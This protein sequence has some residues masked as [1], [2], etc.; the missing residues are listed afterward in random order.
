MSGENSV[1]V[2]KIE[3]NNILLSKLSIQNTD[4]VS[5]NSFFG[6]I[7]SEINSLSQNTKTSED[8]LVEIKEQQNNEEKKGW[9]EKL[10]EKALKIFDYTKLSKEDSKYA[11]NGEIDQ[12]FN[13]GQI[14]DCVLLADLYSISSTQ[15]GQD[16][17][18]DAIKIN[19]DKK[20]N[21]ESYNV[22]FKG[23]DKTYNITHEELKEAERLKLQYE[24]GDSEY[25]F[26]YGDD[27]VLLIELAWIKACADIEELQKENIPLEGFDGP[28]ALNGV[29]PYKFIKA[30]T[31]AVHSTYCGKYLN[32]LSDEQIAQQTPV[33]MEVLENQEEFKF[34]D[35]AF[36]NKEEHNFYY[37][38]DSEKKQFK[39]D[40]EHI[41]IVEQKPSESETGEVIIRNKE[42]GEVLTIKA[43][44]LIKC[45]SSSPLNPEND[46]KLFDYEF[47]RIINSDFVFGAV[48]NNPIEITDIEG[49]KIKLPA[50]HAYGIKEVTDDTITFINP[51]NSDKEFTITKDELYSHDPGFGLSG[52]SIED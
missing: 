27:D 45:V 49:N 6:S 41:Y 43:E 25:H 42:T 10:W 7:F 31:G 4:E 28:A 37:W 21:P 16:I 18:K 22:Y 13:Q 23:Y 33:I 44:E 24:R 36:P 26:S 9:L 1:N 51:W 50:M 47:E 34:E 5:N 2:K 38:V 15:K 40:R 29:T 3:I 17:I 48:G 52:Y 8:N 30:L 32:E 35:I 20:G 19:Y 39:I 12:D 14:G 11:V 46:R